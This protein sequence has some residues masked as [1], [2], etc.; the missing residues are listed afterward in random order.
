VKNSPSRKYSCPDAT[1]TGVV[2]SLGCLLRETGVP[3]RRI[4]LKLADM[5]D[6]RASGEPLL[7]LK[8][9]PGR[10]RARLFR[11]LAI[12]GDPVALAMDDANLTYIAAHLRGPSKPDLRILDWLVARLKPPTRN[13]PHFIVR[14]TRRPRG[15]PLSRHRTI[16][17]GRMVDEKYR[18]L[19]GYNGKK[20]LNRV[21][22]SFSRSSASP[23]V[24]RS[25]ARRAWKYFLEGENK[26]MGAET[27][28]KSIN[29]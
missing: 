13:D 6:K 14:K 1:D 3:D 17:L 5:L 28:K 8:K 9:R 29:C 24:S 26:E 2:S 10:P 11:S 23:R 15:R 18:K 4:L 7:Q 16:E 20:V 27:A 22:L 19:G 25:T 12:I 21:L